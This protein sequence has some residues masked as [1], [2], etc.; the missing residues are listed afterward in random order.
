MTQNQFG[1][2]CL[3]ILGAAIIGAQVSHDGL[4]VKELGPFLTGCFF[5]FLGICIGLFAPTR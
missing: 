3:C 1:G 5:W 4:P 2:L